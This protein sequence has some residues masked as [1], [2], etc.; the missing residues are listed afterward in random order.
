MVSSLEVAAVCCGSSV[1]Y[2]KAM[3]TLLKSEN[4]ALLNQV[5]AGDVPVL[6][7]AKRVK[8][9]ALLVDAYRRADDVDRIAFMRTCGTENILNELAEAAS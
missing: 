4:A 9:R 3:A 6:A 7:A 8:R 1:P 2:V 5:L